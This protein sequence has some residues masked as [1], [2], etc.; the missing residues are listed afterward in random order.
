MTGDREK[1]DSD[2]P[3]L[4]E[5]ASEPDFQAAARDLG[6]SP[7]Q[8]ERALRQSASAGGNGA[9]L[10]RAAWVQLVA[11]LRRNPE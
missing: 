4:P 9:E 6:A 8:A 3:L 11:D 10:Y 2:N 7:A 5:M 1:N